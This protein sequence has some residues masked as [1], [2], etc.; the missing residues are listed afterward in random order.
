MEKEMNGME[1]EG[2]KRGG[3]GRG[4]E[5]VMRAAAAVLSVAAAI[6]MGV[7]RQTKMVA[8]PGLP[9]SFLVTAKTSYQSAFVYFIVANSIASFIAALTLVL[10]L[11]RPR[12]NTILKAAGDVTTAALLFSANGAAGAVGVLGYKGNSHVMW[13]K[14][15]DNFGG[16]CHGV[17]ASLLISLLASIVFLLLVFLALRSLRKN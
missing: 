3:G 10:T 11:A 4:L 17:L 13:N 5:A 16:F 14:V 2:P 9:I 8:L 12:C 15:C 1:M 7:D 6:V